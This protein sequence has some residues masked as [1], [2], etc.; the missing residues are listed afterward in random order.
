MH[1]VPNVIAC[2][3]CDALYGRPALRRGEV[4]R[5]RR[6][7]TEL[8][9]HPGAQ[10]RRILPLS[11]AGLIL[12]AIAN[13]APIVSIEVRGAASQT[14]LLGA[15]IALGAEGRAM[16][17]LLVLATTI[18]FP[19]LELAVL[20]YLLAP[21]RWGPARGVPAGFDWLVR[22]LRSVR[23]WGMIEVFL[24]GVLVAIV[25]LSNMAVV[26]PGTMP[27]PGIAARCTTP[28]ILS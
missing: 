1:E 16:V 13:L 9:R 15:V 3:G 4:A 8:D 26:V 11:L 2:E 21:R 27:G 20:F 17:A 23:P 18:L 25:K 10:R 22:G 14:T 24:L 6:C 28:S 5:C 12:F 7:G 19:L